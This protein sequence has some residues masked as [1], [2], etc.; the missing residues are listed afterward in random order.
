MGHSMGGAETLCY[1]SEGPKHVIDNIRGWLL[2]SPFIAFNA[3]TKPSPFTVF[4]GRVA[5]KILPHR[6]MLF[7]LDAKLLCRDPEVQKEFVEDKLCHD[8]GTLEGLAGNLDRA[9]GLDSGKIRVPP[10]AGEGRKTRIWISHGTSDGVCD[11]GGSKR[12][13]KRLN[14]VNDKELK[15]YDGWFHKCKFFRGAGYTYPSSGVHLDLTANLVHAEPSPDKE[16]YWQDVAD[17][18]LKRSGPLDSLVRSKL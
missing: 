18:I 7:P 16:T 15:L 8:T 6:Q 9:N 12:F 11:C 3:A 17:W 5:G 13:F 14:A 1:A 4:F 2:E 10:D